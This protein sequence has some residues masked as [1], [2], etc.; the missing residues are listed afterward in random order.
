VC[1][2]LGLP[3]TPHVSDRDPRDLRKS[4][5][6]AVLLHESWVFVSHAGSQTHG[7]GT[8]LCPSTNAWLQVS[9]DE[10]TQ[11]HQGRTTVPKVRS[12]PFEFLTRKGHSP[13]RDG[14]RASPLSAGPPH[15]L[16][17]A[18]PLAFASSESPSPCRLSPRP[19]VV[20]ARSCR[21]SLQSR[22][23]SLPHHHDHDHDH[24]RHNHHETMTVR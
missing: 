17:A 4:R 11:S 6:T 19:L 22:L 8:G 9:D 7:R 15:A 16:H 23:P 21:P 20:L 1:P 2:A 14:V 13:S 24:D 3:S 12:L 5:G 10:R 18:H